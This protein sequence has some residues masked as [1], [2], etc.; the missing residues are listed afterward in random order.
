M[1]DCKDLQFHT[2]AVVSVRY[3]KEGNLIASAS[4]DKKVHIYD[5]LTGSFLQVLDEHSLGLNDCRWINNSFLVT[6]SDDKTIKIWDVEIGKSICTLVGHKS[7]VY[8]L[9][10]HPKSDLILSGGFDG[11]IMLN[12][13]KS[14]TCCSNFDAHS[15]VVTSV[16]FHPDGRQYG[17]VSYDGIL[18]V[19]DCYHSS[20]LASFVSNY[21]PISYFVYSPNGNYGLVSTLN[22]Q[23]SLYNMSTETQDQLDT[24]KNTRCVKIFSGHRNRRYSLTSCFCPNNLNPQQATF[25]SGSEDGKIFVWNVNQPIAR[26]YIHKSTQCAP[27]AVLH[28]GFKEAALAVDV[29][30][31][32]GQAAA[33]SRDGEVKLVPLQR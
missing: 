19:W 4:A 2:K 25:I 3:N 14:G 5:S 11:K 1:I 6:C 13:F 18:R 30:P 27:S 21:T 33:V 12:D 16:D 29:C 7:F 23:I 8:S 32:G 31:G 22:D 20:C 15:E 24:N 17:S 26:K 10:V 28:V 9:S